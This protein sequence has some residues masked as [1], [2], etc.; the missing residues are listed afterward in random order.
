MPVVFF[1]QNEVSG[2]QGGIERYL[3]TLI[4]QPGENSLLVTEA[5]S[6]NVTA[7]RS[8]YIGVP[9]P[10]DGV[11]PK[12][13]SYAVGVVLSV[14]KIRRTISRL[15]PCTLE[16]SR[17][18][19]VLFSWLFKGTKVFTLHGTGPARSEGV[20][21]WIHHVS[22]LMLPFAADVVQIVGRDRGGLPRRAY[23]RMA[24]RVRYVDAWYDDVF[25]ITPFRD[26][27]G[28]LR[29]FF[30]GRL[31]PMKNPDLLFKI[32]EAASC[33]SDRGFEFRYFG[34]DEAQ[35]PDGPVREK[36]PSSGLLSA[37]QLAKAIADCHVG[38]LCSGYG[39][40]SPFIVV[41]T[42]ACGRGF[43]LPPLPGLL[44][45]YRDCRGTMFA[46]AYTVDAFIETLSK[47]QAAIRNGLTPEAIASDVSE[48]SKGIMAR[49]IMQRLEAYHG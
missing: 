17:P 22:C 28:P 48:R 36:F 6:D 31:A 26:V 29:V 23:A 7:D 43:I 27:A 20:K 33:G 8:R 45:T 16:M 5:R 24:T 18:E 41:E 32:I 4:E 15:G 9:L 47:M 37:E 25:R 11:F 3:S 30:A 49:Q 14:R 13:V 34:A 1:H 12:W 44:D 21:Y 35:I 38:I 2:K 19:Y 40:G 39:E 46:P 42:L 10:L